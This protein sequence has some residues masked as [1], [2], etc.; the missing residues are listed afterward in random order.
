MK[1]RPSKARPCDPAGPFDRTQAEARFL[2]ELAAPAAVGPTR[3]QLSILED[4]EL[5]ASATLLARLRTDCGCAAGAALLISAL[6]AG[7]VLACRAGA[8]GALEAAVLIAKVLG[9]SLVAMLAGKAAAIL[10]SR[11]RW[12]LER[13]RLIRRFAALQPGSRHVMVR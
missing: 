3:L 10:V 7:S 4:Q 8:A 13:R 6:A 1:Q 9:G 12:Q 5:A 2:I 11:G